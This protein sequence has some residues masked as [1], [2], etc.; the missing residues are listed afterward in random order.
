MKPGD[1]LLDKY[2]PDAD[3]AT[4]EKAREAFRD[5]AHFLL[6]IG[7]RLSA[8]DA[9]ASDSTGTDEGATITEAPEPPL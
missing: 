1:F 6:R 2:F 9:P 7:E 8:D 5:F 4:R 3:E